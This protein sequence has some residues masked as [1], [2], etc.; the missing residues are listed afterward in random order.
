M[1]MDRGLQRRKVPDGTPS[2][3]YKVDRRPFSYSSPLSSLPPLHTTLY[4]HH[5]QWVGSTT[6]LT[7]PPPTTRSP[8]P[9]TRLSSL[10]SSL[11]V[12]LPTRYAPLCIYSITL[13]V[14]HYAPLCR[15]LRLGRS[16]LLLRASPP[17]TLRPPSSCT[18]LFAPI[19]ARGSR[20]DPSIVI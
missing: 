9:P 7:R 19:P 3:V 4:T 1:Q 15:P 14:A 18:F 5:L 10:T 11:L 6:A 12:P 13:P 8:T 17:R 16:T 20:S 2:R